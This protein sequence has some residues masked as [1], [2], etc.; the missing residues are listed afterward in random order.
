M[1][2]SEKKMQIIP[3]MLDITSHRKSFASHLTTSRAFPYTPFAFLFDGPLF[4]NAICNILRPVRPTN[5]STKIHIV[6]YFPS[7]MSIQFPNGVFYNS[8]G[9][10][11]LLKQTVE[12]LIII[13]T[14]SCSLSPLLFLN[15]VF[16]LPHA[17]HFVPERYRIP[18][19]TCAFSIDTILN[20]QCS[21]V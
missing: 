15:R 4:V 6:Y 10:A 7:K 9:K 17:L 13:I 1:E 21:L 18:T 19:S 2:S 5:M 14:S 11:S 20:A 3:P 8:M 16:R 12:K